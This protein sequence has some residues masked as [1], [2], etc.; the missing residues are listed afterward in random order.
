MSNRRKTIIIVSIITGLIA[1]IVLTVF[2][3]PL[4]FG[5]P[6]NFKDSYEQ[7]IYVLNENYPSDIVVLGDDVG[8]RDKLKYRQIT[9][10]TEENLRSEDSFKYT[11]FVINDR[12]GT[13]TLTDEDFALCKKIVDEKAISFY[14]IGTQYLPQLK[15]HG[16]FENEFTDDYMGIAYVLASNPSGRASIHGLWTSLE[17]ENFLI[18]SEL[19]GEVLVY[20]F[21]DDVI[22]KMS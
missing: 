19:L 8:F 4:L 3:A 16:F 6:Q 7:S 11:F 9:E 18:N 22:K 10:M 1:L 2:I 20:S 21:V 15:K 14:Y 17:E 12:K 5:L 13:L